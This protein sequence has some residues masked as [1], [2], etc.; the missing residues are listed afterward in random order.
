MRQFGFP[1]LFLPISPNE[2]T[3][4]SAVWCDQMRDATGRGPTKL[5]LLETVHIAHVFEQL[6]GGYLCGS[7]TN[8]RRTH[9]FG[10]IGTIIRTKSWHIS[11]VLSS[12]N[13][14]LYTSSCLVERSSSFTC[15]FPECY[16]SVGSSRGR[17]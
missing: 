15:R 16:H 3:F 6:D 8:E 17:L 4:P 1:S 10:Y 2:W 13:E 11:I 7:N 14:E 9:V 5:L 12:S